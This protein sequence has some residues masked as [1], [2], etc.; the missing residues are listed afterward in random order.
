MDV[1]AQVPGY[2]VD[3]T[4]IEMQRAVDFCGYAHV[5]AGSDIAPLDKALFTFRRDHSALAIPS[6]VIASILSK[7]LA[8]G[9][10]TVGLEVRVGTHCNFGSTWD[11]ARANARR[12]CEVAR[13]LDMEAVCFLTDASRP[14]QPFIGRGEALQALILTLGEEVGSELRN[15][16][17]LCQAM[18][19]GLV[20]AERTASLDQDSLRQHTKENLMAQG[21]TFDALLRRAKSVASAPVSYVTA[22]A[23]GFLVPELDSLR[24]CIVDE[25]QRASGDRMVFPDPCGVVLKR[26]MG[27]V[28]ERGDVVATLRC[29]RQVSPAFA[30][31]VGKSIRVDE[32]PG[33]KAGY[34]EVRHA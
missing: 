19:R 31:R 30:K 28:V 17:L 21:A 20:G 2:K 16:A 34:E 5:L 12:F 15:H 1:L 4:A 32:N 25:Q 23:S 10:E 11:E 6:L 27:E 7:K 33:Q 9:I 3:L 14:Y 13:L 18:A 24:E 29:D 26:I 22:K 8:V